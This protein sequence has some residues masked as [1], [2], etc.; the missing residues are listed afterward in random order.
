MKKEN[1]KKENIKKEL[2]Q[3]INMFDEREDE[4]QLQFIYYF[5]LGIL[6]NLLNVK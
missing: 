2:I 1:I 6:K 5:T 4:K 3:L